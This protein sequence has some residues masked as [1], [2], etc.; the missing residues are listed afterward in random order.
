[1]ILF[2]TFIIVFNI[3]HFAQLQIY[4]P[5]FGILKQYKQQG[6]K[7]KED[8]IISSGPILSEYDFIVIGASPAGSVLTNRLTEN[9]DWDV[10]LLE[11][12]IDGSIYNDVPALATFYLFTEYNYNYI[13]E[14]NTGA[15]L[16]LVNKRCPWPSGKGVGG[17]TLINALIYTRGN[18]R[19]YDD[20]EKAGNPGWSYDDVLPY[21]KKSENIK[22]PN[23]RESPYHGTDGEVP[24]EYAPFRTKFV[25]KFLQGGIDL[26]VATVDYNGESAVGFAPIQ[27]TMDKGRR[28]TASASFLKPIKNRDNFHISQSSRVTKILINPS[29]K[30]AYGVE[31][32][33]N[34]LRRIVRAR[35]EVI[36][37][38]GA[39]GSP[40]LLML[41]GIGPKDHLEDLEIPV[42]QDLKVGD[43]LQEHISMAGLSFLINESLTVDVA[44]IVRTLPQKFYQ[45]YT[46][47]SGELTAV[48]CEGL[49][50]VKTKYAVPGDYPDIEL[51]FVGLSGFAADAGASL[52]KG[53]GL[54]D[55]IYN[56]VYKS[57]E[58]KQGWSIWPMLLYPKSRGTVRLFSQ[59]PFDQPKIVHNFLADESD[60]KVLV[61]GI[62]WAVNLSET[63]T[64]K[65]FGS[66]LHNTK[67]PGCDNLEFASQEYW[68]CTVRHITTQLHHQSGTCK[69]GPATDSTAVVDHRL[70]VH[71]LINLR[72]A[73][74]S[75]M[76]I[77]PGGHTMAPAY[78]IGEKVAD[79]I[80]EDWFTV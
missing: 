56:K 45:W 78:M 28:V 39:F 70:L 44:T 43:N 61:E 3:L 1:M 21:F 79:M 76:P 80:K 77:I 58:G 6:L 41:S 10:L 7:F 74:A 66:I 5:F 50:Y 48:G 29:T 24:I 37:S 14:R 16:G 75:I 34:G 13:T 55:E 52:R 73:D 54:T 64:F 31:F 40:H 23:L 18:K 63:K 2:S 51:I 9:P 67:I 25:E 57:I 20:W 53:M 30:V 69:M 46:T 4:S 11:A 32:F 19:D 68:E 59:N 17:G 62:K 49:G 15:C 42:I 47:G 38:A 65:N 12:G 60:L 26:G 71:G 72:V 36:V 8:S 27:S 22:I 33:K 35:K